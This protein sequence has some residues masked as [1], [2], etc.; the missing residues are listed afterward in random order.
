MLA[1]KRIAFLMVWLSLVAAS[2]TMP[3]QASA[4]PVIDRALSDV[5]V[6]ETKGCAIVRIGFNFR[7]QYQSHFPPGNGDELRILLQSIDPAQAASQIRVKNESLRPPASRRAAI[8]AIEFDVDRALGLVLRIY[9][10]KDVYFKVGQGTD[11]TSIIVA[12]SGSRPSRSCKP[13]FPSGPGGWRSTVIPRQDPVTPRASPP[14]RQRPVGEISVEDRKKIEE[15]LAEAR[16]ALTRKDL[17]RAIQLLS[18]VLSYPENEHSAEAQEL[19]GV[20]RQR[21]GQLAHARAEYQE[22]LARYPDGRGAGRVRQ[23]LAGITTARQEAETQLRKAKG[24][25]GRSDG[26]TTS[27]GTHWSVSGSVSQ[28]YFRDVGF[29]TLRDESLPPD[30]D[31]DP[32]DQNVFQ[33]ELLTGFDM[34]AEFGNDRYQSKFR[35]SGARDTGFED[36]AIDENSVSSAYLELSAADLDVLTRIGRQTRNTGGVL[37]RFDGALLSWQ[38]REKLRLNGVVGSSVNSR[39]DLPFVDDGMFYGT[40]LDFGPYYDKWNASVF[41]IEQTVDDVLDRRAAGF[42]LRYF[43]VNKNAFTT[44]DYD[45]N[46]NE[47]NTAIFAGNWTLPDTSSVNLA[48]DYRKSPFLLTSNSLQGQPIDLL[49]QLLGIFTEDEIRQFA[50]DRTATSKSATVGYSRPLNEMFQINFDATVSNIS[51]TEASAGVEAIPSTGNEFFYSTQLIG[52]NVFKPGDIFTAGF[53]YADR[54]N[55]DI[56]VADF[57]TRYPFTRKLRVS[58]RLRLSYRENKFDDLTEYAVQPSLRFNYFWKRNLSFEVEAGGQWSDRSQDT[59]TDEE[60]EYFLIAGWRYDF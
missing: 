39:K 38:P 36:D 48:L 53:R 13:V 5:R 33:N 27:D 3:F 2:M 34:I 23:R 18:K 29:R 9:F 49:R 60:L 37:G 10:H 31:E 7:V 26:G 21:N 19:L 30:L 46:F 20:A 11:F 51:S 16:A 14:R 56:Y 17:R 22:Y 47:L 44:V 43:D 57:I 12:V 24:T 6:L 54:S 1:W 25:A 45:F 8:Q 50:I 58:P 59:I 28:F 15:S 52:S 4:E 41:I 35:F 40:S 42:E 32:D 55:S